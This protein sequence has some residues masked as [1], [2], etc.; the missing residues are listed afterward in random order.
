MGFDRIVAIV[1]LLVSQVPCNILDAAMK[2]DHGHFQRNL[3]TSD[4]SQ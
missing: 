3:E 1:L 2:G 4:H